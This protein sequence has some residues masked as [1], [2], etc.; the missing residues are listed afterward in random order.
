MTSSPAA[1]APTLSTSPFNLS[2]ENFQL[3][4]EWQKAHGYPQVDQ[5]GNY[6]SNAYEYYSNETLAAMATQGDSQAM[7]LYAQA[8]MRDADYTTAETF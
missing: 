7:L 1:I 6:F 2:D 8:K 3:F 4:S 5:E